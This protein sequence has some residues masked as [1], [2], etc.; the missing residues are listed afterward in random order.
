LAPAV[1]G[2][3]RR[4]TH[5]AAFASNGGAATAVVAL[6]LFSALCSLALC[7]RPTLYRICDPMALKAKASAA[8][9]AALQK[10]SRE[11]VSAFFSFVYLLHASGQDAAFRR[12]HKIAAHGNSRN[13]SRPILAFFFRKIHRAY[14]KSTLSK[15]GAIIAHGMALGQSPDEFTETLNS[16][17]IENLYEQCKLSVKKESSSEF[18][19][20]R[21]ILLDRSETRRFPMRSL[22]T[23]WAIGWLSS[24]VTEPGCSALWPWSSAMR[25][26]LQNSSPG[27]RGSSAPRMS[28]MPKSPPTHMHTA[29]ITLTPRKPLFAAA[30]RV[31][32]RRPQTKNVVW[33]RRWRMRR[34]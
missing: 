28:D 11:M 21:S 23:N 24:G 6:L 2:R 16:T 25:G 18:E 1:E 15:W 10:S 26:K 32:H 19:L 12:K 7:L 5:Y 17:G 34:A 20:A 27:L 30:S 22:Q 8:S 33:G 29:C 4:F 31:L 14:V 3:A 13:T 9:A